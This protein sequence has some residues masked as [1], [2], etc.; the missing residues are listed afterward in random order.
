MYFSNS[1][2]FSNTDDL[3]QRSR[4]CGSPDSDASFSSTS[5]NCSSFSSSS[6]SPAKLYF[7]I[8]NILSAD[9]G[10]SVD[11]EMK[12]RNMPVD[13]SSPKPNVPVGAVK[14]EGLGEVP[15]WVFCTRYSDRPSGGRRNKRK[16][17]S[18]SSEERRPRGSFNQKQLDRLKEEFE[19]CQYLTT[20]RRKELCLDLGVTENQLKVWFQNNR[21][22]NKKNLQGGR[23]GELATA[24]YTHGIYNH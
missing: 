1:L 23:K 18:P 9:F 21:A 19:V 17:K 22:K 14:S 8:E 24:L 13:L 2:I 12:I 15:A 5:S 11:S 16:N 10:M 20:E 3:Y 7:S 6:V 4:N